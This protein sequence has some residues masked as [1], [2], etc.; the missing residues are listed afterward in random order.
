MAATVIDPSTAYVSR[1]EVDYLD[2]RPTQ[3]GLTGSSWIQVKPYSLDKRDTT[4]QFSLEP[5]PVHF[6]D[7][8]ETKF[9]AQVRIVKDDG[10]LLVGE[11]HSQTTNQRALNRKRHLYLINDDSRSVDDEAYKNMTVETLS[12]EDMLAYPKS[13]AEDVAPINLLAQWLFKTVRVKC[14]P[15]QFMDSGDKLNYISYLTT[16]LMATKSAKRTWMGLGVSEEDAVGE[17]ET[18]EGV[19]FAARK[20][21]FG[22]SQLVTIGGRLGGDM[23]N[24]I[25]KWWPPGNN[26]NVT[27][28]RATDDFLLMHNKGSNKYRLEIVSLSLYFRRHLLLGSL[29]DQK[30]KMLMDGLAM[31][32]PITRYACTNVYLNARQTDFPS[33]PITYG[34]LP[35][36]IWVMFVSKVAFDGSHKRHPGRFGNYN[37]SEIKVIYGTHQLPNTEQIMFFEKNDAHVGPT[38]TTGSMCHWQYEELLRSVGGMYSTNPP[39]ITKAQF[40]KDFCVFAFDL[41]LD[42]KSNDTSWIPIEQGTVTVHCKFRTPLAEP[43]QA[44][45]IAEFENQISYHAD[46]SMTMDYNV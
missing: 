11:A 25:T 4:F 13:S 28:M 21:E 27:L 44:V 17:M 38:P 12:A 9:L 30:R 31:K 19:G 32:I 22:T 3:A 20:E 45:I 8:N 42:Y 26:L 14:G 24:G 36:R 33:T 29:R 46:H 7:L 34:Q 41:G 43:V 40:E 10:S 23:F 15:Y 16:M 35:R 39:D 1:R 37:L 5:S 18:L 2:V 6:I